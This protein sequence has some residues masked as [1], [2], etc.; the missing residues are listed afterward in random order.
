MQSIERE[1]RCEGIPQIDRVT[2]AYILEI[3]QAYLVGS[4]PNG[5][6]VSGN[7]MLIEEIYHRVNDLRSRPTA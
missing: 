7:H 4:N 6:D 3:V 2:I 5:D 1:N